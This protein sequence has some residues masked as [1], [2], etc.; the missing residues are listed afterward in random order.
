MFSV[1]PLEKRVELP[2][3]LDLKEGERTWGPWESLEKAS[4]WGGDGL[5]HGSALGP[6]DAG[7]CF[8]VSASAG[9]PFSPSRPSALHHSLQEEPGVPVSAPARPRGT[10]CLWCAGGRSACDSGRSPL[11]SPSRLFS[12]GYRWLISLFLAEGAVV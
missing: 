1:G 11:L 7:V 2:V 6:V 10:C 12:A 9:L 3:G 5:P 4:T 8:G